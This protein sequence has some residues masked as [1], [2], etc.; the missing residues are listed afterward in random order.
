MEVIVVLIGL[1]IS[2]LL[3][4]AVFNIR[5]NLEKQ[6]A[7][8]IAMVKLLNK[9]ALNT[10]TDAAVTKEILDDLSKKLK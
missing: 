5:R 8:N 7:I 4:W 6:T 3:I 10:G 9:I 1:V 2:V